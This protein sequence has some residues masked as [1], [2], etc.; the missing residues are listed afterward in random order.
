MTGKRIDLTVEGMSCVSCAKTVQNCLL[1]IP[2]VVD[3]VVNFAAGSASVSIDDRLNDVNDLVK[4]VNDCGYYAEIVD[5]YDQF[6]QSLHAEGNSKKQFDEFALALA[7]SLPLWVGM[8]A[9]LFGAENVVPIT[10]QIILATVIQFWCGRHFYEATYFAI[11]AQTANMDVLVAV[12]TTAAYLF[13]MAVYFLDL[14]YPLYFETSA[15]II[16]FIL[17][18]RWLEGYSRGKASEAIENLASLQPKNATVQVG[19]EF[20]TKPIEEISKD[21]II[22]IKPGETIP[23]DGVVLEGQAKVSEATITGESKPLP[24]K[25]DSEVYAGTICINGALKI[26]AL[27]VGAGTLLAEMVRMVKQAQNSKAPIQRIADYVSGIFVPVVIL[28]SLL[29]F[30]AWLYFGGLSQAVVNA[31]SVL[32]VSC[33][34]ALGLATP[35]V[36]VVAGGL[37]AE[38]GVLF[39]EA[40]AIENAQKLSVV[41][42]DKTGTITAG[43]PAVLDII[44]LGNATAHEILILAASLEH[45]SSHPIA[46]AIVAHAN[47]LKL[48]LE[49]VSHFENFPGKGITAEKR[50]KK[51]FVGS[52]RFA[53]SLG[54]STK[55]I[56]VDALENRGHTIC[57]VWSMEGL[58]GY[59]SIADKLRKESIK[60]IQHLHHMG[61]K[62]I[63]LSGDD[64]QTVKTIA[65]EVGIPHFKSEILPDGK[66]EHIHALKKE[67]VVVG[68]V[69]DG[70]NDAPALAAA[71]VGFAIAEGSDIAI[72]TADIVLIHGDIL[73]VVKAIQISKAAFEKIRQNLF[74]AFIYNCIGIPL[75]AFGL[76]NPMIAAAAMALSS[77]CVVLNALALKKKVYKCLRGEYGI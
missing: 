67:G 31:V 66:T 41:A 3:A 6:H 22:L 16:T 5:P 17:L 21:D 55:Q 36:V 33:P 70:I 68:M 72:E 43:K 60:V 48:E 34:C 11:K 57:L 65:Q 49:P 51:Y 64:E 42:F 45:N 77:T 63:I 38:N 32:I 13:S 52:S 2:G 73:G 74:F 50:G 58:L 24:K 29:T 18:G 12:G 40:G 25:K 69:G 7:L 47:H 71:D 23:V 37:A 14:P 9:M 1:K 20:I 53:E 27:H 76:L 28:I 39:K 26:S 62:T 35:T 56:H 19:K 75:A 46:K 44:P 30:L 59:I 10:L 61:I 15:T 4:A 8:I 54:I